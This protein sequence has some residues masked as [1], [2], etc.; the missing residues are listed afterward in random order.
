MASIYNAETGT[1][2]SEGLQ[3]CDTCDEARQA[4]EQHLR[5]QEYPEGVELVDDD[6]TWLV[7]LTAAGEA[8]YTK[9]ATS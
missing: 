8:H 4:A 5:E 1:A 7:T 2:L 3:G 6:G 9:T